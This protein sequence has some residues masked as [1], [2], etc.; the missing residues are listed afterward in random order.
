MKFKGLEKILEGSFI[1]RYNLTYETESGKEKIYEIISRDKNIGNF[2]E[3]SER[4]PDAVVIIM[5]NENGDK[6]LLN[7]EFRMAVGKWV[8]NFPAG[9]IDE[10]EDFKQAAKRELFEE[11]GLFLDKIEEIWHSSFSSIGFSNEQNVCVEGVA[12]GEIRKSD[13]E[14]EEIKA[15][16]YTKDEVKQLLKTEM[17]AARTQAYCQLWVR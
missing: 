17:F 7:K 15:A 11:T 6:I 3:L 12:K 10:G 13:S 5:H 4:L 1:T 8:Y 16:W 14:L 2:S 9:L